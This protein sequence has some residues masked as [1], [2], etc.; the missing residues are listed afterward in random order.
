MF[1][2][3]CTTGI[4]LLLISCSLHG[5]ERHCKKKC[6]EGPRGPQGPQGAQSFPG[7]KGATGSTGPQ[8]ATGQTGSP[9]P[10]GSQGQ[11]GPTGTCQ[12]PS[13]YASL[14]HAGSATVAP[15]GTINLSSFFVSTSSG[16]ADSSGGLEVLQDGI[17]QISYGYCSSG[18]SPLKVGLTI[19]PNAGT[20]VEQLGTALE[21]SSNIAVSAT[22]IMQLNANDQLFLTNFDSSSLSLANI[23]LGGMNAFLT[24][25]RLS[26][27]PTNV[28]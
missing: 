15:G 10:T 19:T 22:V 6:P 28:D 17:Y 12:C 9:G 26:D 13:N 11:Q 2:W 27:L 14:Y 3:L 1:K 7:P 5:E 4:S 18:A 23:A 25:N 20:P 16:M 24:V 8:G 21:S